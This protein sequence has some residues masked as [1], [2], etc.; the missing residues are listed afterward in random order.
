MASPVVPIGQVRTHFKWQYPVALSIVVASIA[1]VSLLLLNF[2]FQ[3][4][5][6]IGLTFW[7]SFL[8]GIIGAGVFLLMLLMTER[9]LT[10]LENNVVPDKSLMAFLYIL[11]GGFVAAITQTSIG[12]LSSNGLQGVFMIGFGWQG[13]LS[14]VGA[15]GSI[16]KAVADLPGVTDANQKDAETMIK[17][18]EKELTDTIAKLETRIKNLQKQQ[19][20]NP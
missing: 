6:N 18:K 14:G 12:V 9:N 17:K 3:P 13:A 19:Q 20:P 16:R 7:G 8:V 1:V 2:F 5:L 10:T 4:Q 15:S 11:S